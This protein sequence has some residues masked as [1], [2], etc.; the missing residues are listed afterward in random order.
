[1]FTS[2]SIG[3]VCWFS[4]L[5]AAPRRVLRPRLFQ[6]VRSPRLRSFSYIDRVEHEELRTW[7][8]HALKVSFL[9]KLVCMDG[10]L[11]E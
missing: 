2:A 10:V 7:R 8:V 11:P 3:T 1:M 6:S 9:T 4:I 5:L